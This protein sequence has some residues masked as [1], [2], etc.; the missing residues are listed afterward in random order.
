MRSELEFSSVTCAVNEAYKP[1]A[2]VPGRKCVQR[3]WQLCGESEVP[4]ARPLHVTSR[5]LSGLSRMLYDH[6]FIFVADRFIGIQ[7]V[8]KAFRRTRKLT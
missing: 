5:P 2:V 8:C 3:S 4:L 1:S 7:N 6:V